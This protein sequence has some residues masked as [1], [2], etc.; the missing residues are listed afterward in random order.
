MR[1]MRNLFPNQISCMP[2][3]YYRPHSALDDRTPAEFA[4]ICADA[5]GCV[6]KLASGHIPRPSQH[7]C[8]RHSL[9]LK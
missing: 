5:E 8:L 7:P 1:A 4:A 6:P 9:E 3:T 2:V